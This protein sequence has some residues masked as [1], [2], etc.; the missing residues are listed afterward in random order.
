M[1]HISF[2]HMII[3]LVVCNACY[4]ESLLWCSPVEGFLVSAF[5]VTVVAAVV[6]VVLVA[7]HDLLVAVGLN[8]AVDDFL[9]VLAHLWQSLPI[10][11]CYQP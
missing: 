3:M 6:V 5:V 7:A 9:W 1:S 8:E 2:T 10:S 11:H 4:S